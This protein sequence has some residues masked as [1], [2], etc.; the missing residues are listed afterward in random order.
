MDF[1]ADAA[2]GEVRSQAVAIGMARAARLAER[3]GRISS[4][5]VARQD[6]LL[7]RF[8]LPFAAPES[9]RDAERLI[10][11]MGRDKKTLDG[12]LRFVLPS[13]LGHVDLVDGIRPDAVKDVLKS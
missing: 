4:D 10:E 8:R 12:Q 3:C 11:I 7:E 5:L 2:G 13:K 1:S 6:R 9:L